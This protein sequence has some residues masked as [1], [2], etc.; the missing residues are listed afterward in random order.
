MVTPRSL[1]DR[2][3]QVITPRSR[4]G[5]LTIVGLLQAS[6]A[7]A[8]GL[9]T[10]LLFDDPRAAFIPVQIL[11]FG[12]GIPYLTFLVSVI[13]R[14]GA[15]KSELATLAATDFLTGLP[16]RRAFL[17]TVAPGGHLASDGVLFYA[18]ADRFKRLNDT[19]GHEAGDRVLCLIAERLRA[20]AEDRGIAARMGGE[21]FAVFFEA[22]DDD[23]IRIIAEAS[24]EGLVVPIPG[25][26]GRT[27]V[28]FS[29]GAVRVATGESLNEVLRSADAAL[30]AAKD[31]GR[32]RLVMARDDPSDS[33]EKRSA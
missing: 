5:W 33:A 26:A 24:S 19:Y 12:I 20:L 6:V 8:A 7:I 28:T 17:E 32:A 14:L 10:F 9:G 18:D 25:G 30:Y 2:L 21:E 29:V 3:V 27:R 11:A 15:V 4:L 31:A 1:L 23:R 13:A 22:S 16:N